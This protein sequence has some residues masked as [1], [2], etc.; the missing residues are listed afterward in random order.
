MNHWIRN[1]QLWNFALAAITGSTLLVTNI[2][3]KSLQLIGSWG[4]VEF[5]YG[6]LSFSW[7]ALQGIETPI[8][9]LRPRQNG[10]LFP[11]DIFKCIFLNEN[12][13]IS[14]RISLKFVPKVR[15]NN[16]PALVQIMAWRRPGDKPLSQPMMVSL[17]TRICITRPQLIAATCPIDEWIVCVPEG[18]HA[19]LTCSKVIPTIFGR[20]SCMLQNHF[21][22]F[23][24]RENKT[25]PRFPCRHHPE[26][27]NSLC[28]RVV[29]CGPF[30]LYGL[31]LI[32]ARISNNMHSKVWDEITY[33]FLNFSHFKTDVITYPC[34]D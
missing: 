20:S 33:P 24:G 5:I 26:W 3:Y 22:L 11:D 1:D 8:N 21:V 10:R 28:P 13:W 25:I 15:I 31:T 23:D 34:W 6:G 29:T 14:L 2:Q 18:E 17:L 32:S 16:I 30:C 4:P 9:T 27:Y 19:Y 12:V 7:I